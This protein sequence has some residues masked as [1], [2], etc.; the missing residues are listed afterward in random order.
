VAKVPRLITAAELD[1]MTPD[2][3]AIAFNERIVTDLD[4][5]PDDFRQEVIDTA[6]RLTA[7]LDQQ[8]PRR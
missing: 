6:H 4:D 1:D 2:Q 7:Q 5:L 3:R 8:Q